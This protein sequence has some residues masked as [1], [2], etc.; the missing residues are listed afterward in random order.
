[1]NEQGPKP[2]FP[3]KEGVKEKTLGEREIKKIIRFIGDEVWPMFDDEKNGFPQREGELPSEHEKRV[4]DSKDKLR[5]ARE[6]LVD[7]YKA[8]P[9]LKPDRI[10]QRDMGIYELLQEDT[11]KE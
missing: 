8:L 2:F 4:L 10:Q 3:E 6:I 9:G 7:I 1:M 5:H 11:N